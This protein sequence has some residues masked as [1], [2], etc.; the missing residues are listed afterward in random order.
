MSDSQAFVE[1]G[2]MVFCSSS[3]CREVSD[4]LVLVEKSF[5]W[6]TRAWVYAKHHPREGQ[7]VPSQWK[8]VALEYQRASLGEQ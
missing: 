2:S 8:R 7:R 4:W 5:N 3:A 6:S 1:L